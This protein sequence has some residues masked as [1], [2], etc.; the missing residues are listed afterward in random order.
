MKPSSILWMHIIFATDGISGFEEEV[1]S[2]NA[3]LMAR[4]PSAVGRYSWSATGPRQSGPGSKADT[5]LRTPRIQPTLA[6][7]QSVSQPQVL[8]IVCAWA[9]SLTVKQ[10]QYYQPVIRNDVTV[11]AIFIVTIICG[12]FGSCGVVS[13]SE[14]RCAIRE[15]QQ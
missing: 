11:A 6:A 12:Q 7:L 14:C 13:H 10:T 3:L 2:R 5:P 9:D 8:T 15:Y 4:P 1:S